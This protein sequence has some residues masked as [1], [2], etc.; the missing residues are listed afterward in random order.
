MLETTAYSFLQNTLVIS[1]PNGNF[2]IGGPDTAGADEGFSWM[3]SEDAN[4][5][6]GGSDGS[7][8]NSMAATQR[9][10]LRLTLQKASPINQK[11][12]QMYAADRANGGINW[13][14]N[15]LTHRDIGRGDFIVGVQCAFTK[16]PNITAAKAAGNNEWEFDVGNIDPILGMGSVFGEVED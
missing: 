8:Q 2:T 12:Q 13:G 1:G 9:G 6:E 15:T 5:Q 14:Q 10:K 7:T 4:I 11:L 3:F 16:F